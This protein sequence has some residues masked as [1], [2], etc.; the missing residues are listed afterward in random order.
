[1]RLILLRLAAAF[2]V[3]FVL[4][5]VGAMAVTGA[6]FGAW[7]I[8]AGAVAV[9][10]AVGAWALGVAYARTGGTA[11]AFGWGGRVVSAALIVCVLCALAWQQSGRSFG[12]HP[13]LW[14]SSIAA[15]FVLC[16]A[17]G[18]RPTRLPAGL[19]LLGL[20]VTALVT[21]VPDRPGSEPRG[22]I[23][24]SLEEAQEKCTGD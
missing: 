22:C 1:M 14:W 5:P 21:V 4:A 23:A 9:V 16:A 24:A 8:A 20:C 6:I 19:A 15:A 7:V 11:G 10:L 18:T 12:P 3:G 17:A 13:S 2:G